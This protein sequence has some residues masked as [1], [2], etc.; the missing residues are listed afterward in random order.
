MAKDVK[1]KK[2]ECVVD[3]A[4]PEEA[5]RPDEPNDIPVMLNRGGVVWITPGRK[6]FLTEE[7]IDKLKTR[8]YRQ[9]K[10][11]KEGVKGFDEAMK[12]EIAEDPHEAAPDEYV[13]IPRFKVRFVN[14]A[15]QSLIEELKLKNK[16]ISDLQKLV[17]KEV[18]NPDKSSE[19]RV[20]SR[21]KVPAGADDENPDDTDNN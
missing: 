13:E 6:T 21:V 7:I 15:D 3:W 10:K 4:F 5:G 19:E 16:Q 20:L 8:S 1:E 12:N 9:Y 2:I 14:E 11:T 17:A 18:R